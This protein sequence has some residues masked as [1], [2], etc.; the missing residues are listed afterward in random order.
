M[1][2]PYYVNKLHSRSQNNLIGQEVYFLDLGHPHGPLNNPCSV[3][4]ADENDDAGGKQP[5]VPVCQSVV[6]LCARYP[7]YDVINCG[8]VYK[9]E[10]TQEGKVSMSYGPI[11]EVKVCVGCPGGIYQCP[12]GAGKQ[13]G[14]SAHHKEPYRKRPVGTIEYE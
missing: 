10:R 13:V 1:L 11:G 3:E 12:L 14:Q 9:R 2:G 4:Y 8:H 5:E 7:W 6:H